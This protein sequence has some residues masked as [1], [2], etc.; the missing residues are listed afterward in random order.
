MMSQ[1][2]NSLHTES[3]ILQEGM[4]HEVRYF[5]QCFFMCVH[6]NFQCP[7]RTLKSC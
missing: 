2:V 6:A 1:K 7:Q 3:H 4:L 5:F